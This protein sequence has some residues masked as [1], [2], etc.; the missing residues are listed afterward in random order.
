MNSISHHTPDAMLAAYA[1]GNLP[2]P[3][4]VVIA[5]HVSMCAECR[6]A[7]EAHQAAGGVVLDETEGAALS[8][9]LRDRVLKSERGRIQP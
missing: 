9:R 7:L 8:D 6:A 3:F 4:A 2:H 5:T 1:A